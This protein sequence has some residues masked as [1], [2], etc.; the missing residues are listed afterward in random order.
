MA[1][2]LDTF[3]TSRLK[4]HVYF[5]ALCPNILPIDYQFIVASWLFP[6]SP[7]LVLG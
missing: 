6:S 1:R 4:V 7:A 2:L 3:H 5:P